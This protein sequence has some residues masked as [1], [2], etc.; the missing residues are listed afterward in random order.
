MLGASWALSGVEAA[1]RGSPGLP[2]AEGRMVLWLF[3]ECQLSSCTDGIWFRS[4]EVPAAARS[5]NFWEE[6]LQ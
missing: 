3:D 6:L 4:R 1:A 2:G 5:L